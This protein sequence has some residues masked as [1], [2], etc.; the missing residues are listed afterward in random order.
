MSKDLNTNTTNSDIEIMQRI[1]EADNDSIKDLYDKYSPLLYALVKKILK[2]KHQAEEI[3]SDIFI[4]IQ[5]RI[6]YFD[7]NTKN[8]YTWLITLAK[9]R[10]VYELRKKEGKIENIPGEPEVEYIIPK[11]SHLTEPLELGKAIELKN[12]IET[13]LNKLTNAQQYVIYLA[14]YEGLNRPEIAKKLKIP[15]TTVESKIK[16]SLINLN[17][18]FIGKFSLFTV[19]NEIVEMIYPFV[20]GC[21]DYEE[22]IKTYD[23]FKASEPFPW[24]LLGEYQNLVSL[25]PVILEFEYPSEELWEKISNRIFHL[26]NMKKGKNKII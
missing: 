4:I 1:Y 6:N 9:N 7:F 15:Y 13:G 22:Q 26:K 25:L 14:Y 24:K 19:K 3:L 23:R 18:N 11:L 21:L 2:D 16:T 5:K 12:N 17:E 8:S 10:A 20:L